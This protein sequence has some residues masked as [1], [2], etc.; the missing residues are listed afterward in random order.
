M[1]HTGDY[2]Y[3]NIQQQQSL[4]RTNIAFHATNQTVQTQRMRE[5]ILRRTVCREWYLNYAI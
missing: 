4:S 2:K 3:Q 1:L 5:E